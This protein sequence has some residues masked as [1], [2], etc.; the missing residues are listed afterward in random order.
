L[1]PG[2][3]VDSQEPRRMEA[4]MS[5]M[6]CCSSWRLMTGC[7]DAEVGDVIFAGVL[8][9]EDLAFGAAFAEAAGDEDAADFSDDG[10]GALFFDV[11]GV[12]FYDFD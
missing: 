2:R 6:P 9:G 8:G 11:F 1:V 3:R 12:D 4:P 5:V 7:A 10:F